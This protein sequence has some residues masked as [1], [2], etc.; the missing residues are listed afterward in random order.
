MKKYI[1]PEVEIVTLEVQDVIMASIE[2]EEEPDTL[3]E[4]IAGNIGINYGFISKLF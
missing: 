1:K 2:N 4:I 3:K